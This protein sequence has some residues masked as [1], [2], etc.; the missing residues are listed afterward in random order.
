MYNPTL[1][2]DDAG[3]LTVHIGL[4]GVSVWK[5]LPPEFKTWSPSGIETHL[6]NMIPPMIEELKALRADKLKKLKRKAR[7]EGKKRRVHAGSTD[8]LSNAGDKTPPDGAA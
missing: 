1:L 2:V 6:N 5:P 7:N 4:G 8:Q 3:N